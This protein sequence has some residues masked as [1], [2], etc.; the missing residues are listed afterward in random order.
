MRPQPDG[1]KP[2]SWWKQPAALALLASNFVPLAG[3]LYF[4]WRLFPVMLLFW[5]DNVVIG[6]YTVAR[7]RLMRRDRGA[8]SGSGSLEWQARQARGFAFGYFFFTLIH[9]LFLILIFGS[10]DLRRPEYAHRSLIDHLADIL[11]EPQFGIAVL[12][13][14]AS[15]G[16]DLFDDYRRSQAFE[17]ANASEV[18]GASFGRVILL[19]LVLLGGGALAVWLREPLAALVLLIVLKTAGDIFAHAASHRPDRR[20]APAGRALRTRSRWATR[21]ASC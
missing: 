11:Q 6:L 15:R 7:L 10:F 1:G 20:P 16:F 4:D 18:M 3:V 19:H 14:V 8:A 13:L 2:A 21:S 5:L 12:A 9:G 17:N